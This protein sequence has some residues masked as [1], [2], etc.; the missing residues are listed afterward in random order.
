MGEGEDY[1][2][3]PPTKEGSLA[4]GRCGGHSAGDLAEDR[5][6]A[7]RNAWHDSACGNRDKTSHQSI[8]NE[9]LASG[10]FP[11]SQLP[12][13]I[14]DPCHFLCLLFIPATNFLRHYE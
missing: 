4:R 9:V 13:Q 8:F 7:G 1:P 6:D 5:A 3:R 12:N 10:V 2:D 11:N 14:S